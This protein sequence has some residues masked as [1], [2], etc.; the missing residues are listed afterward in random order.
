[1]L[2]GALA[3]GDGGPKHRAERRINRGEISMHAA[4]NEA[5]EIWHFTSLNERADYFPIGGVPADEHQ[6]G[7]AGRGQT[8]ETGQWL[9]TPAI[10]A[11]GTEA[12]RAEGHRAKREERRG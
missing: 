5:G 11:P 1:M 3:S 6:P 8:N 7:R 10:F 9:C 12:F 4:S 2:V